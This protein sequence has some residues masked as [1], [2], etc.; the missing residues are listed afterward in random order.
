MRIFEVGDVYFRVTYRDCGMLYPS[1]E[2]FVFVGT[3]LSNEDSEETFYF[4][5]A[6]EYAEHGSIEGSIG[7]PRHVVCLTKKDAST[8]LDGFQLTR[9][10]ESCEAGRKRN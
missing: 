9:I 5:P 2:T 3:N 10:L 4:Q 1:I 7:G 6:A 8:M